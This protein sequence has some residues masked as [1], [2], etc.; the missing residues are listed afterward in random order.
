MVKKKKIQVQILDLSLAW[1]SFRID[2]FISVESMWYNILILVWKH[3][4]FPQSFFISS[5]LLL[6]FVDIILVSKS[7]FKKK[8]SFKNIFSNL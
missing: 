3:V 7:K 5:S 6:W 4:A 2:S 1:L 8:F